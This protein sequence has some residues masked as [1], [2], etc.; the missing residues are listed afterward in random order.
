MYMWIVFYA[1][2]FGK[3]QLF[4]AHVCK[5]MNVVETSVGECTSY[6]QMTSVQNFSKMVL[7]SSDG[8]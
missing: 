5:A 7:E 3:C 8:E 6:E 4:K 2:M 1:V